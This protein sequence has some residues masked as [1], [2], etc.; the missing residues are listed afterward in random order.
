MVES[1]THEAPRVGLQLLFSLGLLAA[2]ISHSLIFSRLSQ[3]MQ[4]VFLLISLC[5]P[6]LMQLHGGIWLIFTGFAAVPIVKMSTPAIH[7]VVLGSEIFIVGDSCFELWPALLSPAK[8]L[9]HFQLIG[10][11]LIASYMLAC[12]A[13][14][15][16]LKKVKT[17]RRCRIRTTT[18]C[19]A[20]AEYDGR[21]YGYISELS[22]RPELEHDIL[23]MDPVFDTPPV[24]AANSC[25]A[26]YRPLPLLAP[27]S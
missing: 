2:A 17:K 16:S 22:S 23:K 13:F 12:F 4:E 5:C 21:G 1:N 10:C 8:L 20:H 3:F 11:G 15:I 24:H 26:V 7:P 18:F 25:Y 19:V 9:I 27:A 6:A 14:G